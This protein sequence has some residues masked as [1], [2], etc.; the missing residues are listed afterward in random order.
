[1]ADYKIKKGDNLTKIA[2]RYGT[3]VDALVK[4]NNIKDK[5]LIITG[6]T[7]NIPGSAA[8]KA[9]AARTATK[10]MDSTDRKPAAK[11]RDYGVSKYN[12]RM[13][14]TKGKSVREMARGAY[15]LASGKTARDKGRKTIVQKA[16]VNT[17]AVAATLAGGSALK[18]AKAAK[19]A[20]TARA[21]PAGKPAPRELSS[22]PKGRAQAL[23]RTTTRKSNV[24]PKNVSNVGSVA[25]A[26]ARVQKLEAGM[27]KGIATKGEVNE[28]KLMLRAEVQRAAKRAK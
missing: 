23:A 8:K 21:L 12:E 27:K 4:A 3:T 9:S 19:A 26:K 15:N 2:K 24:V 16:G 11:S 18:A 20:K 6:R 28:A 10:A 13:S 25:R 22:G 7:L 17:T 1:M 14:R 5:N